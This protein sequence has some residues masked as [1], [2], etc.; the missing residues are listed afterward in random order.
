MIAEVIVDV[1]AQAVDRTFDYAV[2]EDMQETAAPGCRVHVPFGPRPV[3]GFITNL[4]DSSDIPTSRLRAV[5]KLIDLT[6][7]LT[8]ELMRTAD[9]VCQETLSL[10]A[11]VL[12][13]ML[14]QA[15]RAVYRKKV[16]AATDAGERHFSSVLPIEDWDTWQLHAPAAERSQLLAAVRKGDL[17]VEPQVST[18]DGSKKQYVYEAA[19][20]ATFLSAEELSAK[21]PKQAEILKQ[22]L[23]AGKALPAAMLGSDNARGT[24]E[25]LVKKQL[26][27]KRQEIVE[28]DPFAGKNVQSDEALLLFDDQKE[29]LDK[30][31]D[32]IYNEYHRVFMIRGVTGSGKTEV[33]L[34]AIERVLQKGQ[35]AVVLVPEISLTPQMVHRFRA[36]FGSLVAV[37]H[38][39]LSK[40]EKYDEWRKIREGR[41]KVVV[42]ARSAVFAPFQNIGIFI[43]D[44]EHESSY[45]QEEAPRY[46][47]RQAAIIRAEQFQCPVVLGSATPS[48]ESYARAEKGVYELLTME[49]RV[50]EQVMPHVHVVD[51]RAQLKEGN[52]SMF[53]RPLLDAIKQ[54]I[55]K[56]EQTVLMLN[57]RGYSSFIMCRDCGYVPQCRHCDI[58]LT[59]HRSSHSLQCHY[60]GYLETLPSVCPECE[61][62]QIRF[63]GTG[64]QK[65]EEELY[66]VLPGVKVIRMD[67][68]TTTR[69]GSH[70]RLLESFGK[71]E[72]DILLGTQMIAKGLDFPN[73]TLAGVLA[74]DSMLHL[75]D[76]RSA[77][78]TFQL[79]TQLAGRA[80]RHEKQGEV[81]I[82]TYSPDHYSITD[83]IKHDFTGFYEKEMYLRR[84][85]GYPPYYYLT[86]VHVSHTDLNQ[87]VTATEKIGT[88]LRNS[89]SEQAKILGPVAS[90]IPRI[91]DRFRYQCMIKYKREPD[92][93][94]ILKNMLSAWQKETAGT[95]LQLSIDTNPYMMM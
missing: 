31:S 82:Q 66:Q 88:Y 25:A 36:R 43:V 18:K 21:A 91:K 10:K 58:S 69:K 33:Y 73:I 72:A 71:G 4:K 37:M 57:R 5:K 86:M 45:K 94:N 17:I 87:A 50:N 85:G 22:L 7:V 16:V 39:A 49:N 65:V 11:S 54:R 95:D 83:V 70:E 29:A 32:S 48:L 12:K 44:E 35:E 24:A 52:R 64:T 78:R 92:L 75:P 26:V 53:S 89:L 2:P 84:V 40:G 20:E 79:L 6:P 63:F 38:S 74:A 8:E 61:S 14:P 41:V 19:P 30:I 55:E 15:M 77:E 90:P 80:G 56:G 34:Q 9:I 28:R 93:S 27:Q 76:F 60:C 42:G 68:D 1:P 59:Y 51:M 3:Q 46:H 81:F 47:A 23:N 67:V 13:A 62:D